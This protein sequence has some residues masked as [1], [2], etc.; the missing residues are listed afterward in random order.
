MD[1]SVATARRHGA[2][3]SSTKKQGA[4]LYM[5]EIMAHADRQNI[6]NPNQKGGIRQTDME[7]SRMRNVREGKKDGYEASIRFAASMCM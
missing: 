1:V 6:T 4:K 5:Y 2:K 3:S 7:T